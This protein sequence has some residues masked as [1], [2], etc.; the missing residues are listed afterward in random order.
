MNIPAGF[1]EF[2]DILFG[3]CAEAP[4]R[5]LNACRPGVR[6]ECKAPIGSA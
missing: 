2:D 3:P 1:E 6:R 4:S 5:A